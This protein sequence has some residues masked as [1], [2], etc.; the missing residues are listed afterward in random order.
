MTVSYGTVLVRILAYPLLLSEPLLCMCEFSLL[1]RLL[2]FFGRK[3]H[4]WVSEVLR[5]CQKLHIDDP[6][7]H[8]RS[9]HPSK[10]NPLRVHSL[11]P[12][13]LTETKF[14]DKFAS[15]TLELES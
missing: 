12:Q 5:S 4:Q 9:A 8:I 13:K 6:L 15:R 3:F 2:V 14:G 1:I 11:T 10:I 7:N